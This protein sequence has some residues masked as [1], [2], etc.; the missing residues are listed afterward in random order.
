M[1]NVVPLLSAL[2]NLFDAISLHAFTPFLLA[3]MLKLTN[4]PGLALH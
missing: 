3:K 2:T 4:F 1:L